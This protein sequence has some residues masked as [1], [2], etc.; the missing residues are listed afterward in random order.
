FKEKLS[1]ISGVNSVSWLDD[2]LGKDILTTTPFEFLDSSI[3]KNYYK[4]GNA[5]LSVSI[6]SGRDLETVNAIYDLIGESGAVG[7]DAANSAA[8]Q[9]MTE[10]EVLSA[11]A[12]LLPIILIIL[13]LST[14][15]WLEPLLFLITIGVAVVINMGTTALFGEISYVTQTVTP[16]LQLAV[17]MDYAIF[18]LH[19]FYE[20]RNCSE[21]NEAMRLAV[22]R[23]LPTVAAS[24]ATTVIG[25]LALSFMRFGIGSDLGIHLAKGVVLS[26]L[27]VMI[28]LPALTLVSYKLLDK[29]RHKSF[30]PSFR[31]ISKGLLKIRIPF[32]LLALIVVIPCF[33]AQSNTTFIYGAGGTVKNSRVE[34]DIA[35]IEETF[36][37]ENLLVLLV[38]KESVGKEAE[39]CNELTSIP[40]VTSVV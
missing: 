18:L 10:S 5:L 36:G 12:F 20:Y 19:S 14:T 33:I 16:V 29:T 21:P 17:S 35:L 9:S 6:D 38:P 31:K 32:L 13:L 11:V 37:K 2:V 24:A 8:F 3:T 30:V 15:S 25:F 40:N 39:L 1:A 27:S 26:F 23:S 28:F 7:G 22:K 34:K 4:D